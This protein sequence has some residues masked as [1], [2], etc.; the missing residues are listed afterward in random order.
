MVGMA[1]EGEVTCRLGSVLGSE[2]EKQK[3]ENRS[4]SSDVIVPT[5]LM[6]FG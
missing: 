3:L 5:E 6:M 4:T 1:P 2:V